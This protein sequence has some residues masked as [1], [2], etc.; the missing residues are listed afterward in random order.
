MEENNKKHQVQVVRLSAKQFAIHEKDRKIYGGYFNMGLWNFYKTMSHIFSIL[1]IRQLKTKKTDNDYVES[2]LFSEENLHLV[3]RCLQQFF[4][5]NTEESKIKQDLRRILRLDDNE[6]ANLQLKNDEELEDL[7]NSLHLTNEQ[8]LKFQKLLFRHFPILGPIM[9][10]VISYQINKEVKKAIEGETN[11]NKKKNKK[12]QVVNSYEILRDVTLAQCLNELANLGECLTDCRNYYTHYKPYNS[13][14]AQRKMFKRQYDI[15]KRMDK[16][17]TAS[18]RIDKN[19]SA[20]T[21][22]E[23]EFLTGTEHFNKVDKKY[24]ERESF[25]FRTIGMREASDSNKDKD[26]TVT[27]VSESCKALSDFGIAY[28]CA[29]FLSKTYERKFFEEIKLLETSPL[30]FEIPPSC[31]YLKKVLK[32][33]MTDGEI[34][35]NFRDYCKLDITDQDLVKYVKSFVADFYSKKEDGSIED[36]D[37][38]KVTIQVYLGNPFDNNENRLM[39]EILAVYRVRMPKGRS[40]DSQSSDFTLGMDMLNELR[41]C[42]MEL[43]DTLPLEGQQFF[44]DEVKRENDYTPETV[45]RLRSTDRFTE[46]ALRYIDEQKKFK[47]LRFQIRLGSFRYCFYDKVCVDGE[48]RVR[49]IQKEVNG[50]GRIQDL[51][52]ERKAKW[53]DKL[54]KADRKSV[55]LEHEDIYLDLLQFEKDHKDSMPYVTDRRAEYNIHNNRIGLLW[56]INPEDKEAF[57]DEELYRLLERKQYLQGQGLYYLPELVTTGEGINRKSPLDMP[58]PLC[59]ISTRELTAMMFYQYLQENY[60]DKNGNHYHDV[61]QIIKAKYY[62]LINFFSDIKNGIFEFQDNEQALHEHLMKTYELLLADIPTKIRNYI[63]RKEE[64]CT[65]MEKLAEQTTNGILFPRMEKLEQRL[66]SYKEDRGKIGDKTNSYG[67]KSFVDVRHGSLAK[68]LIK[69]IVEWQ[70]SSN[71]GRDKITSLNYTALQAFLSVYGQNMKYGSRELYEILLRSNL[72]K[73]K[74]ES[75]SSDKGKT[76]GLNKLNLPLINNPIAHPFLDNVLNR[77][78]RNIEEFYLFYLEEEIGEIDHLIKNMMKAKDQIASLKN[79]PFIHANRMRYQDRSNE[80]TIKQLAS[81]YLEIS[82]KDSEGNVT[83]HHAVIL[84]PD[85]MFINYIRTILTENFKD[86]EE[87]MNEINRQENPEKYKQNGKH[88]NSK[89]N[90]AHHI[91][92]FFEK[93]MGDRSQDYYYAED[94]KHD[95]EQVDIHG[96]F[97]VQNKEDYSR[98][99]RNYDVFRLLRDNRKGAEVMP[100]YLSPQQINNQISRR[101]KDIN[102]NDIPLDDERTTDDAPR[103]LKEIQ[104]RIDRLVAK[105]RQAAIDKSSNPKNGK[106]SNPKSD[107]QLDEADKELHDK[108]ENAVKFC[109]ENEKA[110]RRYKTQDIVLF[111]LAKQLI[112]KVIGNDESAES[113]EKFKLENICKDNFLR[114]TVRH[115]FSVITSEGNPVKVVQPNMSLKN[116]GEFYRLLSDDRFISMLEQLKSFDSFNYN[117]LMAELTTYDN[118]RS[119]IF[120]IIHKVEENI[121]NQKEILHDKNHDLDEFYIKNNKSNMAKRN[122]FREMLELLKDIDSS[123]LTEEE[124]DMFVRIRNA[125]SHNHMRIPFS[126]WMTEDELKNYKE[127]MAKDDEPKQK[128]NAKRI[129]PPAISD[130]ILKKA[131]ELKEKSGVKDPSKDNQQK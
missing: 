121:Y 51:E 67:K 26:G 47:D 64:E 9:A 39:K 15:A 71:N 90:S 46:L 58:S 43:Y 112:G 65:P 125:F 73:K 91:T 85:S 37:I 49:R 38:P 68:Y 41:K 111:L 126:Q 61:E 81:R 27:S 6:D 62:G 17:L 88:D 21:T 23:M 34:T 127:W 14:K 110:I 96:N 118:Y 50:F 60:H 57:H 101:A 117:K 74:Y 76:V 2:P 16:A 75:L 79:I 32:Q 119:M 113:S 54:Q 22:E 8:I 24:I 56:N 66:R 11:E 80:D 72:L 100:Y 44:E 98:F 120:G 77:G 31:E 122:S 70:G 63:L 82:D 105:K 29:T 25:Y 129:A 20:V 131:D 7:M 30:L 124:C 36:D 1:G 109:K 86:N 52:T 123:K 104:Q 84:L 13:L 92:Q 53:E 87:F 48:E 10:D 106:K 116:Y 89:T 95:E 130:H 114:Q 99:A 42:P 12:S 103:F 4:E 45:K 28:F 107:Q 108:L 55:K 115:E 94:S 33:E 128:K 69:D 35:K 59:S 97:P 40:L 18:R 78:P 93:V 102:G 3:L 83:N 5:G 19:R